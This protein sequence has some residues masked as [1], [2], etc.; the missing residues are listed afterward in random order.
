MTSAN[1]GSLSNLLASEAQSPK[2]PKESMTVSTEDSRDAIV[3]EKK[4]KSKRGGKKK[5]SSRKTTIESLES[6]LNDM[7][8]EPKQKKTSR[9]AV[10]ISTQDSLQKSPDSKTKKNKRSGKKK[11]KL[12]DLETS[13]TELLTDDDGDSN[14]GVKEALAVLTKD[15]LSISPRSSSS[16]SSGP[17]KSK[18]PRDLGSVLGRLDAPKDFGRGEDDEDTFCGGTPN[19]AP[20]VKANIKSPSIGKKQLR[21]NAMMMPKDDSDSEEEDLFESFDSNPFR[22]PY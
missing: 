6:S 13:L 14:G 20:Q 19:E 12:P 10:T 8:R 4:K 21:S 7:D 2:Q 17:K 1:E 11:S 15:L 5:S 9:D 18:K 3:G 22:M 16:S